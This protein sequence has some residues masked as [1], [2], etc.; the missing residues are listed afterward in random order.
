M[1]P[2]EH[3]AQLVS[4]P[5][6]LRRARLHGVPRRFALGAC[7]PFVLERGQTKL[8]EPPVK[9]GVMG[10]H[11]IRAGDSG[12]DTGFVQ[13]LPRDILIPDARESRDGFRNRASRI[14]KTTVALKDAMDQT[15]A[16]M[17]F[18]E[19]VAEIDDLIR[20]L[21]QPGR[22]GIDDH[23]HT[24][25]CRID[26]IKRGVARR[27][28]E[29]AHH[30]VIAGGF[31]LLCEGF[32][33]HGQCSRWT[34]QACERAGGVTSGLGADATRSRKAFPGLKW[35][36]RRSGTSTDTPVLGLRPVRGGAEF[37][38]KLPK[39]LISIRCPS[40]RASCIA[41]RIR[42]TAVPVTFSDRCG[43]RCARRSQRSDFSML[44]V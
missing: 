15:G 22:L 1:G 17:E 33:I 39:S 19:D 20:L 40:A 5:L 12:F 43:K 4:E 37:T 9:G 7:P 11:Q 44:G 10:Y 32:V 36:R 16:G 38:L 8:E 31:E 34:D 6:E 41:A 13:A 27:G 23:H 28:R 30:P 42:E 26:T 25:L 35:G 24:K 29:A 18:S 2:V 21:V 14:L 3:A